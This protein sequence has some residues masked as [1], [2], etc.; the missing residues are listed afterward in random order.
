[1]TIVVLGVLA[2]QDLLNGSEPPWKVY[3]IVAGV[4]LVVGLWPKPGGT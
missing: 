3:G 4:A 2:A 1:L